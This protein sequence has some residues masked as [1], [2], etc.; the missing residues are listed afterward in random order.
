MGSSKLKISGHPTDIFR[1]HGQG[2][3]GYPGAI[4]LITK[5][6]GR[7][8]V[9]KLMRMY[10]SPAGKVHLFGTLPVCGLEDVSN[11]I[12]YGLGNIW[13]TRSRV[14]EFKHKG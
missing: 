8:V 5:L 12:D 9:E 14:H 11:I 6:P 13:R 3:G 7:V 2:A 1:Y 10:E 4:A